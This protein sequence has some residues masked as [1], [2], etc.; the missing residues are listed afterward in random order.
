MSGAL[1]DTVTDRY[2][3]SFFFSGAMTV[4]EDALLLSLE[5]V[6]VA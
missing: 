2:A 6:R 1:L 3:G 5:P 4:I